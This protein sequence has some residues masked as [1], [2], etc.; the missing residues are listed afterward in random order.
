MASPI[1][2]VALV[3]QERR[4]G[5]C[6]CWGLPGGEAK[7]TAESDNENSLTNLG[8]T[9]IGR[10]NWQT[11]DVIAFAGIAGVAPKCFYKSLIMIAPVLT[12]DAFLER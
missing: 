9:V 12:F 10:V 7:I 2:A 11:P 8:H 6:W 5:M 4:F 3:M 1:A